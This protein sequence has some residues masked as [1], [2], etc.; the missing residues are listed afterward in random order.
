MGDLRKQFQPETYKN[1]QGSKYQNRFK[2]YSPKDYFCTRALTSTRDHHKPETTETGDRRSS[3]KGQK[4]SLNCTLIV[5]LFRE[6]GVEIRT[7]PPPFL[8][9][10]LE[11]FCMAAKTE[12]E[13]DAR[14]SQA[15]KSLSPLPVPEIESQSKCNLVS[16][17]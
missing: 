10:V 13:L 1:S 2:H 12:F 5:I 15:V 9:L 3:L 4:T 11:K 14:L 8:D 16:F 6:Q 7:P 17:L